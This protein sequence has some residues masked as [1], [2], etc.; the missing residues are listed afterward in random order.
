MTLNQY[1]AIGGVI[2][3]FSLIFFLLGVF[4]GYNDSALRE[5]IK[6]E[7]ACINHALIKKRDDF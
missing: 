5:L 6:Q 4:A 1:F 3:T 7:T 2:A